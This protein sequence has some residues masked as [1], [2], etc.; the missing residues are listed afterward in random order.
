MAKAWKKGTEQIDLQGDRYNTR[1]I[2]N[3]QKDDVIMYPFCY[4][5][6]GSRNG[7][8]EGWVRCVGRIA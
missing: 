2:F 3:V 5:Y 1:V 8:Y 7:E 4:V 6:V